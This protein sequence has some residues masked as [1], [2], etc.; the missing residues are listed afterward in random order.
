MAERL[1]AAVLGTVDKIRDLL[2]FFDLSASIPSNLSN[3]IKYCN[4]KMDGPEMIVLIRNAIVHSQEAKRKT[5]QS[6]PSIV[7]AEVLQ[8]GIFYIEYILLKTLK[9]SGPIFNRSE[10]VLYQ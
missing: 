10:K 2:V 3:T 9:Y 6:I 5:L 7:Y 1:I 4:N 8:L